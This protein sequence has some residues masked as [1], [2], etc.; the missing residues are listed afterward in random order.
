MATQDTIEQIKGVRYSLPEF[1]GKGSPIDDKLGSYPRPGDNVDPKEKRLYYCLL[2]LAPGDY[3]GIHSPTNWTIESARHFPGK[4]QRFFFHMNCKYGY[5]IVMLIN[6][7][8]GHLFS[9]SSIAVRLIKNL[10][11]L[12]EVSCAIC[13]GT[14]ITHI[15]ICLHVGIIEDMLD[16]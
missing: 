13:S 10:F 3:H 14:T 1:L 2:Y 12:N 15:F 8:V 9:V 16:R 7:N 4:F 11:V 6:I 5:T